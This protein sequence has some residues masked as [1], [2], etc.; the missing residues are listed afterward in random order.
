MNY[1]QRLADRYV[2]VWNET[3]P[4]HRRRAIAEL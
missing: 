1:A 2:A 3:D 4:D